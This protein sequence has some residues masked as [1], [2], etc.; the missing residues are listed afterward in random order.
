MRVQ[1]HAQRWSNWR[2]APENVLHGLQVSPGRSQ[3]TLIT[4]GEPGQP[5]RIRGEGS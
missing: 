5:L 1:T 4:P 2:W 3:L